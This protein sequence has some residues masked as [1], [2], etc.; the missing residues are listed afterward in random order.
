M[1][2]RLLLRVRLLQGLPGEEMIAF[3]VMEQAPVEPFAYVNSVWLTKEGAERRIVE[4]KETRKGTDAWYDT[5][6]VF[7]ASSLTRAEI[8]KGHG[9]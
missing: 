4:L 5:Y 7:D 1:Q 6:C 3:V 2:E 8:D 9:K